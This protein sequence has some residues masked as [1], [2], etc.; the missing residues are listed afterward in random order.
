MHLKDA[1]L[2]LMP[3]FL[4]KIEDHERTLSLVAI[5][6]QSIKSH[7]PIA[8]SCGDLGQKLRLTFG[9]FRLARCMGNLQRALNVKPIK[10]TGA[11]PLDFCDEQGNFCKYPGLSAWGAGQRL[12]SVQ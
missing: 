7:L 10:M 4:E 6:L 3:I 9:G 11:A 5:T 2:A 12:L 1:T 8:R